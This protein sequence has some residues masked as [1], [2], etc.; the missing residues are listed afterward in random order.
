MSLKNGNKIQETATVV[1][2]QDYE[3]VTYG[4]THRNKSLSDGFCTTWQLTGSR[5]E[6][7]RRL[8]DAWVGAA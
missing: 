2:K 5:S 8:L 6:E 3:G 7:A 1:Q 4:N